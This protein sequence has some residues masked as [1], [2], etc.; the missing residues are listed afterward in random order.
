MRKESFVW[1]VSHT[2]EN[3]TEFISLSNGEVLYYGGFWITM[4]RRLADG[5]K[6]IIDLG[7][8]GLKRYPEG[9][10]FYKA[11]DSYHITKLKQ[12]SDLTI[13]DIS[14]HEVS[15]DCDISC[16][17]SYTAF[18]KRSNNNICCSKHIIINI[19]FNDGTRASISASDDPVWLDAKVGMKVQHYTF[20]A[21]NV[22]SLV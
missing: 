7:S 3:E 10:L 14:Q 9:T 4:W 12:L 22:Y 6:V 1:I 16:D 13:C 17:V 15:S 21:M 2:I 19:L 11:G 20:K 18:N 5:S 8:H